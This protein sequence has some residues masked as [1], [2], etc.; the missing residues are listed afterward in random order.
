MAYVVMACVS[1]QVAASW[2]TKSRRD[3][4][5]GRSDGALFFVFNISAHADGPTTQKQKA[6]G[7]VVD[8]KAP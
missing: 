4:S 7:R 5:F 3:S 2:R 6:E 1:V 8:P